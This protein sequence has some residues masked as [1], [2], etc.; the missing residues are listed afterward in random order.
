MKNRSFLHAIVFIII[1]CSG[2]P[3]TKISQPKWYTDVSI[4]GVEFYINGEPTFTGRYWN[5]Y[6]IEDLLL[7]SRMVQGIFDDL[8]PETYHLWVYPDT[9]IYGIL[10]AIPGSLY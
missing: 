3:E 7:N 1:S 6:K 8:N 9:K 10:T 5:G 4:K 2:S